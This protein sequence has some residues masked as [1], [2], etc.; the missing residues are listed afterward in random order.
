[1]WV[2]ITRWQIDV[3]ETV[4]SGRVRGC[5]RWCSGQWWR[6]LWSWH[7]SLSA[8]C[9]RSYTWPFQSPACL[10]ILYSAILTG[11]ASGC[12]VLTNHSRVSF[13]R[14]L[15]LVVPRKLSIPLLLFLD[16]GARLLDRV[17]RLLYCGSRKPAWSQF[18]HIHGQA[19]VGLFQLYT[20]SLPCH[21]SRHVEYLNDISF[22]SCL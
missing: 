2:C 1:M 11:K 20:T 3:F 7:W 17:F 12:M 9:G 4:S 6:Y 21:C 18:G 13:H 5:G 19:H 15:H 16:L 14:S 8:S 22:R 10:R